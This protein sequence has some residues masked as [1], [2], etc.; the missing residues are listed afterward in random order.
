MF[1]FSSAGAHEKQKVLWR[2]SSFDVRPCEIAIANM[3]ETAGGTRGV[4]AARRRIQMRE[5]KIRKITDISRRRM[6]DTKRN[7]GLQ[8]VVKM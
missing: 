3:D 1:R 7:R 6:E 5:D 4:V 8:K 2:N